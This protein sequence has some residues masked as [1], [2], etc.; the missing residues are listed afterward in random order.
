MS[1]LISTLIETPWLLTLCVAMV[2]LCVGSFL[3]VVIHRLPHMMHDEWRQQSLEYLNITLVGPP[4]APYTLSTPASSCPNCQHKIQWYENIPLVSWLFL[5]GKCSDCKNPISIRYPMVELG[6]LLASL[7]VLHAFGPTLQMLCG[8]IFTWMLIAL[9]GIDFDTQ[10][11]PDSLTFPLAGM[12]LLISIN[13]T[14]ATPTQSILGYI[15]GFLIL[16]V[17]NQAYKIIRKEE[18]MGGGDFKLLAALGAWVG[19]PSL[20]LII[21]LSSCVGAIIGLALKAIEGESRPYPF[22]PYLAIAGW[23][24]LLYGDQITSAYMATFTRPM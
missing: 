7:L 20:L 8:L 4:T 23:I 18:G 1:T 9:S 10:Y 19:A 14:F 15:I 13:H 16:W 3:N 2:S 24:T 5:K 6:T 21:L 22:G 11:L 17:V 12:G